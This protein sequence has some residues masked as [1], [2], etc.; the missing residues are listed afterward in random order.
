MPD[1]KY[2]YIEIEPGSRIYIVCGVQSLR[3]YILCRGIYS[4]GCPST[5]YRFLRRRIYRYWK[6]YSSNMIGEISRAKF[7][8]GIYT[9]DALTI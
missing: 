9:M 2:I 3:V 5:I 8:R 7:L 6:Y 1:S 4:C